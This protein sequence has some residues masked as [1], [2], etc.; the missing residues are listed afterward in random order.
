M[1]QEAIEGAALP[2]YRTYTSMSMEGEAAV[3]R[4][5]IWAAWLEQTLAHFCS[6]LIDGGASVGSTLTEGMTASELIQTS[7]RA[8]AFSSF[9]AV[10]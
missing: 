8:R 5:A 10:V 7:K 6:A 3:G 1:N 2:D 4:I 9:A